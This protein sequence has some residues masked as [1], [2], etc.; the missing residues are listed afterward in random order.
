MDLLMRSQ[1]QKIDEMLNAV[2]R[3][4]ELKAAPAPMPEKSAY[5]G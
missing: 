5:L 3:S 4:Y 2:K 1:F